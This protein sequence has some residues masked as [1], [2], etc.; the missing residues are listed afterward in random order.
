MSRKMLPLYTG[1]IAIVSVMLGT[2]AG[3]AQTKPAYMDSSLP[4]AKRVD[5]LVGQMTLAE[6]VS[7]MQ[8]HSD[9]R[10]FGLWSALFFAAVCLLIRFDRCQRGVKPAWNRAL[11]SSPSQKREGWGTLHPGLVGSRER[12]DIVLTIY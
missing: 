1:L 11:L 5:D 6:K 4:V 7:Q 3:V 12:Q 10:S 9:C 2:P 8:N